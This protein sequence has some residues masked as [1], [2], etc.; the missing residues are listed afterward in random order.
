ME[1]IGVMLI[2]IAPLA[3]GASAIWRR[4]LDLPLDY[5]YRGLAR[6]RGSG[7][8]AIGIVLIGFAGILL[9]A[10]LQ[11]VFQPQARRLSAH[12]TG[13][14]LA[15][16]GVVGIFAGVA[17]LNKSILYDEKPIARFR[18]I[19]DRISGLLMILFSLVALAAGL[20]DA[21]SPEAFVRVRRDI[22]LFVLDAI[23]R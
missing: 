19:P 16:V 8:I 1:G 20:L 18:L 21:W 7:A 15:G 12:Q 9:T 5:T 11:S 10:G 22:A 3:L 14:I 4:H 23:R 13:M 2:G 17:Q 6:Y